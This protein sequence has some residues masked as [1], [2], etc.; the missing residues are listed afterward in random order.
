MP[1]IDLGYRNWDGERSPRFL[2]PLAITGTSLRLVWRAVWLR[3]LLM[4]AMLPMIPV[5]VCFFMYEQIP[6]SDGLKRAALEVSSELFESNP[7]LRDAIVSDS[8][9]ARHLVWA[10][11]LLGFFRYPQAILMVV[12][13]GLVAPRI[14]SYD[15][16]SRAYLL[17]FSRPLTVV[18]YL[19][20]KAL[21][22]IVLLALTS[23]IPA[24]GVYCLGLAFSPDL[25]T[26][27]ETWDL[28]LRIIAAS[29][30]LA[31]P[32]AALAIL[33]SSFTSESRYAAFAWFTTWGL[34]WVTY[35]VLT[36]SA[37]FSND[38]TAVPKYVTLVSPY[39]ALGQIQ[40]AIFGTLADNGEASGAIL[41][42]SVVTICSMM[43]AYQRVAAQLRI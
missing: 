42:V 22:L 41:L 13:F 38:F 24:L 28:P 17:Y 16:R 43:I 5:G 6:E 2:R 15:I 20:G 18:E 3:R 35:L 40:A 21:V 36:S 29:V 37:L 33:Y 1:I 27:F 34:G 39:H 11:L 25:W 10:N 14:I 4:I 8:P 12:L 26:F 30:T 32:T 9:E 23:T 31:L 7:Q 19:I